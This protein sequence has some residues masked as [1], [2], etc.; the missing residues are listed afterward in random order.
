M[1]LTTDYKM[2][3]SSK[4]VNL[5]YKERYYVCSHCTPKI[6]FKE[7]QK[8]QY[9]NHMLSEHYIDVSADKLTPQQIIEKRRKYLEMRQKEID[10]INENAMKRYYAKK[11][12]LVEKGKLKPR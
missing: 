3:H 9:R 7:E 8:I 1:T 2:A 11:Q 12:A 4:P 10:R 5:H 6:I